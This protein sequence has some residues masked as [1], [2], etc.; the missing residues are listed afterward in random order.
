MISKRIATTYWAFG[1]LMKFAHPKSINVEDMRVVCDLADS[2]GTIRARDI[3]FPVIN[4][5]FEMDEAEVAGLL[6]MSV[7]ELRRSGLG[8]QIFNPEAPPPTEPEVPPIGDDIREEPVEPGPTGPVLP[9]MDDSKPVLQ[10][11]CKEHGIEFVP[12]DTKA[13]LLEAIKAKFAG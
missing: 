11:F 12:R 10:A 5:H 3:S 6:D 4:P 8:N 9:T 13:M 7:H 2:A 1:K